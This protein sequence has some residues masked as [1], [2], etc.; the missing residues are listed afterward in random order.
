MYAAKEISKAYILG[1]NPQTR[2]ERHEAVF[3]EVQMMGRVNSQYCIQVTELIETD[4]EFYIIQ[5]YSNGLS[6]LDL[7]NYR[8]KNGVGP[9]N[10]KEANLLLKQLIAGVKDL[11]RCEVVH[12]D[13]N[14]KNVLIH[15]PDLEPKE[16]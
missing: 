7:L 12:R 3:Q 2:Q 8:I 16:E 1:D 11:Y 4:H 5:E 10:E 14:I 13:L 9:L 6:I 15:F